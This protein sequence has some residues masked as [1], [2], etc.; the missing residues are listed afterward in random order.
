MHSSGFHSLPSHS[1]TQHQASHPSNDLYLSMPTSHVYSAVTTT[2]AAAAAKPTLRHSG[3]VP[4]LQHSTAEYLTTKGQFNSTRTSTHLHDFQK[5]LNES[6]LKSSRDALA[7][8]LEKSKYQIKEFEGRV[9]KV[10]LY[11]VIDMCRT[12]DQVSLLDSQLMEKSSMIEEYVNEL[13]QLRSE[14]ARIKKRQEKEISE[15]KEECSRDLEEVSHQML[16]SATTSHY[17]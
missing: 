6:T 9:S 14:M 17:Q 13:S 8:D 4:T 12:F 2:T 1:P 3:S 15:S 5:Q 16:L 7:T 10:S 11:D